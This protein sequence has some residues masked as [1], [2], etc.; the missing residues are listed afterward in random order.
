MYLAL[1]IIFLILT[2]AIA[3]AIAFTLARSFK[4]GGE[5][6]SKKN[7]FY[8]A[9]TLLTVY[10]LYLT[11]SAFNGETLDFFYCFS[12]IGDSLDIFKFDAKASLIYPICQSYPIF[13]AD[14]ILAAVV[15][16]AT[17]VI[18]V[19]SF[20]SQRIR[21]FIVVRRAVKR[22]CDFVIGD[23]PDALAYVKN[24]GNCVITGGVSR[25]R[26]AEL[27]KTGLPVVKAPFGSPAF[28]GKIKNTEHDFVAFRDGNRSYTDIIEAFAAVRQAGC[29]ARL[30]LEANQ[31]EMKILKEKFI[32]EA[33][34]LAG[35]HLFGFSKY[36][37]MARRFVVDY[38][39]TK[40]IPRDFYND[41]FSLKDGKDINVVF[42]GFGKVNYQLFRMCAMQF[43][44]A[45]E[46]AGK[47]NAR[48]VHYYVYD[49]EEKALH[50]EFFSRIL[51]EFDEEFKDC[52]FPKP[53]RICDLEVK[54]L[55][56][57]SVE[58]KKKFASLVNKDSYTYFVIS[59]D[60][61]LAD[62]SYAMTVNR[63]LKHEENYKIFVRAKNSRG[64]R[65]N[66]GDGSVI[67]FGE[68]KTLCSHDNIVNDDLTCLAQ[69]INLLYSNISDPPAWLKDAKELSAKEQGAVL[70]SRLQD[71]LNREYM[72]AKWEELPYIEQASNLYHALNLPFKLNLL[73]FDMVKK[74]VAKEGVPEEVFNEKYINSGRADGYSDYAFF[75]GRETGNVLAF[76][77]HLRWNALY[78]L[79]D[80]GQ[81]KKSE[82]RVVEKTKADGTTVKTLPH[83]DTSKKLHACLTTYYGLHEL[84]K[85]KYETLYGEKLTEDIYKTDDRLRELG[86]IYA[87]DYM[88]LDRLY[89]EITAMDYVL[90]RN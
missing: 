16:V 35:A 31:N 30:H 85:F 71:P 18:S 54:A 13:Y 24:S 51:Y 23:S 46:K 53:E 49:S 20:F 11:A 40:F 10:F 57:N 47:L 60:D 48:P 42:I 26:Y 5:L 67:Y 8:L 65:L 52:D 55:D 4:D 80:Y 43:Q 29:K 73:G 22:N 1:G 59:L 25:R 15:S 86:K 12:L 84:I 58:A 66:G 41:N 81:M 45:G 69:R 63:L 87:Y 39:I 33:G 75:F 36:E 21:N 79:Y 61:D 6:I 56:I 82:M 83:K 90:I 28:I 68:E 78:I 70:S 38:P 64:E 32:S 37:L 17:A 72:L 74:S 76:I 7:L 9:P 34:G 89:S 88:D 3:A 19:A 77:E 2:V 27:L 62:A 44:F 14:F 50:N